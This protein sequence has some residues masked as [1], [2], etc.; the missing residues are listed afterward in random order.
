MKQK[1]KKAKAKVL[2]FFNNPKAKL[3]VNVIFLKTRE[4]MDKVC[5]RKTEKWVVGNSLKNRIY[6]F[7]PDVFHKVSS[8]PKKE[9]SPVLVHEI[10][11][12]YQQQNFKFNFPM[13]LNEG[14]A[15][16]VANQTKKKFKKSDIRRC[17]TFKE[18]EKN[19]QYNSSGSFVQ[20]LIK[21]Y[22]KNKLIMLMKSLKKYET[23]KSFN[24]KFK[25]V[26]NEDFD[27]VVVRWLK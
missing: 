17:H 2:K 14:I 15:Y 18:W 7:H 10:C 25:E 13:W 26:F 3:N 1:I 11:H 9:F 27:S 20:Y 19:H 4:E 24:N 22:G 21:K 23:K 5:K 16:V 12:V 6:I 8:H